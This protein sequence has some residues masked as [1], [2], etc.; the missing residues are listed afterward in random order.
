MYVNVPWSDTTYSAG[1]GL[2]LSGT[3]FSNSG[4][5]GVKGNSESSYRTGQVNL[6]SANIGAIPLGTN[7]N[8]QNLRRPLHLNGLND[9]TLDSKINTLRANR[10][11]FLP[12]D[13]IIIEKTTDGGTTWVD[14]GF[15]DSTK[16]GLFSETRT[17]VN[18]PL[19]NGVRSLECGLR[20][21]ITAMKYNV[22]SGTAETSKYNYWNSDYVISAE[23]YNQLK[24]MYFWVSAV[25]D[26][27]SIKVERATG[28]KPNNWSVI[29]EDTSW[30]ATGWSGNDYVR[31][32]QNT[33]GG[34]TTQTSNYWN[35]RITFMTRGA[36]GG[37][38]LAT[39]ST[40]AS[41]SIMEIRGYGDTWWTAGNNY[42]ANDCLYSHDYLK[43]VTFPAK[44]TATEFI[45]D[46]AWSKVTN[47]PTTLSGYGITDSIL[48]WQT[49]T[50]AATNIYDFGVYVAQGAGGATGPA[51]QNYYT[52][53]NIPYR[54]AFGNTKADYGWS[55]A[56]STSND[57]RLFYRTSDGN[58]WGDWVEIAHI[59]A[60]TAVGSATQPV[61]VSNT[62]VVTACTSYANASVNHATSAD[63]ATSA[64]KAGTSAIWLYANNN[65]EINFGGTNTGTTIFMGY[66]AT[67]SRPIPTKFVFGNSTGTADLQAKTI[68]LGS[69][70]T[71]YIS[72]T[73]Y[74]GNAATATKA[75]QDKNGNDITT[76]YV[77]IDTTQ[78]ITGR[79][80]FENLAA[81]TFKPNS[82]TDECNIS[83][84]A[85]LGAL[86]FSF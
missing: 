18:I 70:T 66:R 37:T 75:T 9:N 39:S 83:Y 78:T 59:N 50:T 84:D 19:L 64:T 65:N 35:Y 4:V 61:Y 82:G 68:Y 81:V 67:D 30:G 46:L 77:T 63:S 15:A 1:T 79:K 56:G 62:G 53:L 49:S 54:K 58:T 17:G 69:G 24:E 21:T 51:N 36:N 45:G 57:K 71:S 38:T 8:T 29:F 47:K 32:G 11:A 74:T 40:T 55:I 5:T 34:G 76:K 13:Q 10:L 3:T 86:V 43:N 7:G 48:K 27:I 73:Q 20:I 44:V 26:T 60:G 72:N 22:P 25:N 16:I 12:A 52:M 28:A 2:S 42:A 31:F 6:T 23:R 41:Q 80:T 14:A 85:A 33:F